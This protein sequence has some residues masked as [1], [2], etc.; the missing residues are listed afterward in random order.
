MQ[1]REGRAFSGLLGFVCQLFCCKTDHIH[2]QLDAGFI[3][4]SLDVHCRRVQRPA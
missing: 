3:S 4:Q 1:K 2:L